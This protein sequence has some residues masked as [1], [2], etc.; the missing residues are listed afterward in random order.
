MASALKLIHVFVAFWFVAGLI[1]RG[2]TLGRARSS[3]DIREVAALVDAAGRFEKLMVIP[4]SFGVLVTGL[5]TRWSQGG[6]FT[7]HGS[8]WLLTALLLFLT[9]IPLVPLVFLPR[10]KVFEAALADAKQRGRPT[11]ELASAFR[12]RAVAAAHTYELIAVAVVIW[13]MVLKPF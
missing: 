10:G 9:Q 2:I 8:W 4:A 1:G 6:P 5:I 13:L 3:E 11:A 7:G 12:D